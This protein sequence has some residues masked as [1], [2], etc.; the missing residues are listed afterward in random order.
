M[1]KAFRR[2]VATYRR[3]F[4]TIAPLA[5][6]VLVPWAIIAGLLRELADGL[7]WDGLLSD[8]VI[9]AGSLALSGVGY[10]LLVGLITEVVV[11]S[12]HGRA[13]L[14]L[15]ATAHAIPYATLI[16]VDLL[17]VTAITVGLELLLI[18]GLIAAARFGLAP[19]VI[20][21]EHHHAAES[22]R[23]SHELSRGHAISVLAV[24]SAVLVLTTLLAI[25]FKLL[26]A[27]LFAD[28][29]AEI[30]GLLAAGIIVKPLAAVI[31]VELA[32]ELIDEV[33]AAR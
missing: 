27:G 5:V 26:A 20:E 10:F 21:I 18:P 25:P 13:R 22:L 3:E 19:V 6:L 23:R 29:I 4:R 31:E 7:A 9:A 8:L 12:R 30:V 33:G 24:L 1:G 28:A 2:G 11:A 16:A 32:L 14:S 17:V 15:A